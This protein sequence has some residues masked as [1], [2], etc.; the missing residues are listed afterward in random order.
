MHEYHLQHSCLQVICRD[1]CL[2][3][4]HG[5]PQSSTAA[6]LSLLPSPPPQAL[7]RGRLDGLAFSADCVLVW[8]RIDPKQRIMKASSLQSIWSVS[9]QRVVAGCAIYTSQGGWMGFQF[10]CI[11]VIRA[12]RT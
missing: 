5:C 6:P 11:V 3:A 4:A 8:Q 10:R 7:G 9:Q 1:A 2:L 12:G